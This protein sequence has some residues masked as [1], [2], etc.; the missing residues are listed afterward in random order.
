[1]RTLL[2][3]LKTALVN[4]GL[5]RRKFAEQA[6]LDHT[7]LSKIFADKA[8]L[9]ARNVAR[10]MVQLDGPSG[11]EFLNAYLAEQADEVQAELRKL[12]KTPADRPISPRKSTKTIP[13]T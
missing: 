12:R 3:L 9:G 2:T 6:G 10:I 7:H 13:R 4:S 8:G 11:E 5:S 1:M